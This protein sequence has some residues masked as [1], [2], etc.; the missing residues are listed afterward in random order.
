MG[1]ISARHAVNGP[2]PHCR[3]GLPRPYASRVPHF[4]LIYQSMSG[5][6][7]GTKGTFT[8]TGGS[9]SAAAGPLFYVTNSTGTITI[10]GVT[11]TAAGGTLVQAAADSWGTSG[12]N[13]GTVVFTASGETLTGNVIDRRVACGAIADFVVV[14]MQPNHHRHRPLGLRVVVEVPAN[15]VAEEHLH[16]GRVR[17]RPPVGITRSTPVS[18]SSPL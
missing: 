1:T 3:K 12:S 10:T 18:S 16:A 14:R 6:A 4:L 15:A 11:C 17:A 5:D 9:L 8:M 13:G 2:M 7:E